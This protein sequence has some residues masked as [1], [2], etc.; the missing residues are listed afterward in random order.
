MGYSFRKGASCAVPAEV[1]VAEFERIREDS[2][3]LTASAVVTAAKPTDAPLHPAFEWNDRRAAE[4]YRLNQA[5]TMIRDVTVRIENR[6]P[7]IAYVHVSVPASREGV[8]EPITEVVAQ[9]DK[10]VV[11]IM[12][13]ERRTAAC[14]HQAETIK[15][16]ARESGSPEML[17]KIALAAE[18]LATATIAIQSL[19]VH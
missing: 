10:M 18:A 14:A 2:G 7:V 12:E 17:A 6:E 11:A 8:Y 3:S 4:K 15:Q 5:R 9:P 1:V 19:S 16:L 13:W